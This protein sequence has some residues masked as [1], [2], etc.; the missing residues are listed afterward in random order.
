MSESSCPSVPRSRDIMDEIEVVERITREVL[1][2]IRGITPKDQDG[3][4]P[5]GK[6]IAPNCSNALVIVLSGKLPPDSLCREIG[7][8]AEGK[9]VLAIIISKWASGEL[10]PHRLRESLGDMK[11]MDEADIGGPAAISSVLG[12]TDSIYLPDLDYASGS[13]IANFSPVTPAE[14]LIC[15]ALI[16]GKNVISGDALFSRY[17][18]ERTPACARTVIGELEKKLMAV[19]IALL[20]DDRSLSDLPAVKEAME[21]CPR[22]LDECIGCGLCV[23]LSSEAVRN[24]VEAGADRIGASLGVIAPDPGI[25]KLIDHTILKPDATEDQVRKLCSEAREYGFATVCINPAYV[26]LAA[27][28]LKG[29]HVGITPV[30][31]FPL[32]ATTPTSKA[33]ETWDA[34]AIGATEIDMV[35]NVGAL[36]SGND[37][38]VRRDM[39]AVVEAARGGAI[40]KVILENALL[41]D[42]EKVRG[43]LLAKMAGADFVKTS[44]G[45]GPGGATVEDIAL[46]RK[47]VGPEMGIKAAG[48]IR[49]RQTAKAMVAAGATRIG[50]SASVAI[51]KGG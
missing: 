48:G 40:V 29:T 38:L 46:M 4:G 13:R 15:E 42:E 2:R 39:E 3:A 41:T 43:C 31:G 8:I 21:K 45:F 28:E 22:S 51:T 5:P 49:D 44:T 20:S 18:G 47:T 7:A 23:N 33:M 14:R 16:A 26:A 17:T 32:G 19:G 1:E 50:A 35:I 24:I 30:V 11:I 12:G 6:G 37:D 34:I 36:K 9:T 27:E 10:G 25:G